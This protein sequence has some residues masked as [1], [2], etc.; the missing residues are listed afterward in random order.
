MRVQSGMNVCTCP[1]SHDEAFDVHARVPETET[2][3]DRALDPSPSREKTSLGCAR[4]V[5]LLPRCA[6]HNKD[7]SPQGKS[8]ARSRRP[9]VV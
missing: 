9:G 7:L 8:S 2:G 3:K 6:C 1:L 4:G 5:A